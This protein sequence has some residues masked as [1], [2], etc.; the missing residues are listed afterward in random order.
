M[1]GSKHLLQFEMPL[2]MSS[3]VQV[4]FLSGLDSNGHEDC[5]NVG[6]GGD[7]SHVY[8]KFF[9]FNLQGFRKRAT[10]VLSDSKSKVRKKLETFVWKAVAKYLRKSEEFRIQSSLQ[11]EKQDFKDD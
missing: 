7:L 6:Y 11:V 5:L 2:M 8:I 10:L 1:S 9:S 3:G 4:N